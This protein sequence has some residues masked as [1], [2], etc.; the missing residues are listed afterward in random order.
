M[1]YHH[2]VNE[3]SHVVSNARRVPSTIRSRSA[4]GV[5]TSGQNRIPQV[6][7]AS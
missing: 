3:I 5:P 2:S 7:L 6:E 4:A 1:K